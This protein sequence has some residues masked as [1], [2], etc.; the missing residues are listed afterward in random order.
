MYVDIKCL[1]CSA[2]MPKNCRE[3]NISEVIQA[4]WPVMFTYSY[5]N[6]RRNLKKGALFSTDPT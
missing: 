2:L 6:N 1:I 5:P 4:P 3:A